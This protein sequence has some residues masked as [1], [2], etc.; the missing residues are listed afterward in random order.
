MINPMQLL[1]QMQGH[2]L[3]NKIMPMVQGK[4]P[5]ELEQYVRN[6]YQSQG[7]D[8]NQVANQFGIKL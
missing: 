2:P 8:I 7:V 4:N 5:K 1:Q 6:L 3:F